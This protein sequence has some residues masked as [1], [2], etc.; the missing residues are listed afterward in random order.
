V[1]YNSPF[2]IAPYKI[3]TNILYRFLPKFGAILF[4]FKKK[5]KEKIMNNVAEKKLH[6][7]GAV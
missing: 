7:L 2:L 6:V 3:A 1:E 4:Y 5:Y